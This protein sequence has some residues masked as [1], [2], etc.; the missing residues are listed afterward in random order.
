[1]FKDI[2]IRLCNQNKESPSAVCRNVGIAPATFS[3]WNDDSV[4][5]KAT[6]QRIADYFG[7]TVDYLLGKEEVPTPSRADAALS[8]KEAAMLAGMRAL[9]D[10]QVDQL[11][12]YMEFLLQ[13]R[14][15]KDGE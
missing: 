4:P 6:L 12:Q 1:M 10:D 7:V 13:Q 14:K 9:D 5:R 2:F 11:L 8:A 15:K 3:C